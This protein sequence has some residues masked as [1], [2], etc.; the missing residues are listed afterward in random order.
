MRK[1]KRGNLGWGG[2]RVLGVSR[3]THEHR[4]C[5]FDPKRLIG[6]ESLAARSGC[7]L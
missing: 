4:T 5:S 1:S 2:F 7:E 3:G 6:A